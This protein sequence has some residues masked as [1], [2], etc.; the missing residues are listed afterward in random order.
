MRNEELHRLSENMA[1]NLSN[2][3]CRIETTNECAPLDLTRFNQSDVNQ[4]PMYNNNSSPRGS[5]N[6]G[7]FRGGYRDNQRH[8]T[9]NQS[10]ANRGSGYSGGNG[11]NSYGGG[12]GGGGNRDNQSFS[13]PVNYSPSNME[14]RGQPP[15]LFGNS[16]FRGRNPHNFRNRFP[17]ADRPPFDGNERPPPLPFS[18][19][20]RFRG[21]EQQ[22][23]QQQQGIMPASPM[24][25]PPPLMQQRIQDFTQNRPLLADFCGTL[26][27]PP[28][29]P[30]RGPLNNYPEDSSSLLLSTNLS[31]NSQVEPLAPSSCANDESEEC[32][33]YDNIVQPRHAEESEATTT[34]SQGK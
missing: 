7:N 29:P 17:I 15:P 2:V 1:M 14:N 31:V 4:A 11:R 3:D 9:G 10:Y 21:P 27:P 26:P 33:L 25:G 34:E 19:Q 30:A 20:G 24:L 23:Q 5:G 12:G 16:P 6:R 18:P 28:P 8:S 22:Q 32:D 13:A